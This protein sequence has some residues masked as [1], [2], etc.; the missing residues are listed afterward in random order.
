M[1]LSHCIHLRSFCYWI[2]MFSNNPRSNRLYWD[3]LLALLA[4]VPAHL[5]SLD[6]VKIWICMSGE[7]K[8]LTQ[9]LCDFEWKALEDSLG[10]IEEL[11]CVEVS[12]EH[13]GGNKSTDDGAWRTVQEKLPVMKEKGL[14]KHGEGRSGTR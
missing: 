1:N 7:P 12:L 8:L 3:G 5:P 6:R 9:Q 10:R 13:R 14:L 4:E 11:K 2:F